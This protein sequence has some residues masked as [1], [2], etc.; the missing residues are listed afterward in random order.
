MLRPTP[1]RP[2][3]A[4]RSGAA[5]ARRS[6][7][8]AGQR[9]GGE[10]LQLVDENL[11]PLSLHVRATRSARP[12][13]QA[14]VAP[15]GPGVITAASPLCRTADRVPPNGGTCVT[16]MRA[17]SMS[18]QLKATVGY[19]SGPGAATSGVHGPP[20]TNARATRGRDTFRHAG[21]GGCRRGDQRSRDPSTGVAGY[22]R[23]RTGLSAGDQFSLAAFRS[24][25]RP[26]PDLGA[27]VAG[28]GHL[29]GTPEAPL[30]NRWTP[31]R[32]SAAR[33]R[34]CS[35]SAAAAALRRWRWRRTSRTST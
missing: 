28:T 30:P 15:A 16:E 9:T 7:S 25:R 24:V 29:R 35:R 11:V 23:A 34:L 17:T 12:D 5:A 18:Y 14:C 27:A 2:R 19:Q 21:G 22:E 1:R 33:R 8:R 20:W 31:V 4:T 10:S 32:G 26:A 13:P 3:T 6:P